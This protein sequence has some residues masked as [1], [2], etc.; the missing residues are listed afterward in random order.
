[1]IH[2]RLLVILPRT[3]YHLGHLQQKLYFNQKVIFDFF[4]FFFFSNRMVTLT[5]FLNTWTVNSQHWLFTVH[6]FRLF[7]LIFS[8]SLSPSPIPLLLQPTL[9]HRPFP[10]N[11]NL[12]TGLPLHPLHRPFPP[13]HNPG[14]GLPLH[15]LLGIPSRPNNQTKYLG[16]RSSVCKASFEASATDNLPVAWKP[17]D[18]APSAL[19]SRGNP[20]DNIRLISKSLLFRAWIS[21]SNSIPPVSSFMKSGSWSGRDVGS[22]SLSSAHRYFLFRTPLPESSSFWVL[23]ALSVLE[24]GW[25]SHRLRRRKRRVGEMGWG[26]GWGRPESEREKWK[27]KMKNKEKD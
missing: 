3:N 21:G 10:P 12:G 4:C 26:W 20:D 6:V 16:T 8:L 27:K 5:I 9:L 25:G 18:R 11:H 19:S 17:R 15:P 1:M 2:V 23:L 22:F 14:T 13:N 24:S 7:L